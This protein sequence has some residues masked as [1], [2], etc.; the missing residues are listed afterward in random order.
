MILKDPIHIVW[1]ISPSVTRYLVKIYPFLDSWEMKIWIIHMSRD[2]ESSWHLV[3]PFILNKYIHPFGLSTQNIIVL[4]ILCSYFFILGTISY[5][6][7]LNFSTEGSLSKF[8][9]ETAHSASSSTDVDALKFDWC[10]MI[11]STV[12]KISR[13]SYDDNKLINKGSVPYCGSNDNNSTGVSLS[14][15]E[16]H[17]LKIQCG[18]LA[19]EIPPLSTAKVLIDV[20]G[21]VCPESVKCDECLPQTLGDELTFSSAV[22]LDS[23]SDSDNV[24][25]TKIYTDTISGLQKNITIYNNHIFLI[26][27]GG[28][29]GVPRPRRPSPGPPLWHPYYRRDSRTHLRAGHP[30]VK[31]TG[32]RSANES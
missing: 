1:K 13:M 21:Y 4:W 22:T 30:Q 15:D 2:A 17:P 26:Y 7:D 5:N 3:V 9:F 29:G 32:A 19:W 12:A 23:D 10:N 16:N 27:M 25:S 20:G 31:Y 28:G 14:H 18:Y 24:Y 6:F 8:L 11:N